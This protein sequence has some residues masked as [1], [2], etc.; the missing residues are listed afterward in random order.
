MRKLIIVISLLVVLF[1]CTAPKTVLE[2]DKHITADNNTKKISEEDII[3]DQEKPKKVEEENPVEEKISKEVSEESLS[4]EEPSQFQLRDIQYELDSTGESFK[5]TNLRLIIDN[6]T[7]KNLDTTAKIYVDNELYDEINP[8][9]IE[10]FSTLNQTFTISGVKLPFSE[11]KE[12]KVKIYEGNR[13][14]S[15]LKQLLKLSSGPSVNANITKIGFRVEDDK[16]WVENVTIR[17]E[18]HVGDHLLWTA[19]F[20]AFDESDPS[21]L[22]SI[23]YDEFE[24]PLILS[25]QTLEE[26]FPVE[27]RSIGNLGANKT[28]ILRLYDKNVLKKEV[29]L[30]QVVG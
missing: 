8:H 16:F 22:K 21:A 3:E 23:P 19:K 5:L 26:T 25:N 13:V 14:I 24:L 29:T 17:V 7:D 12:I 2:P 18:N 27:G 1:G 28:F 20:Y 4:K 10:E 15:E 11:N 30:Y 9:S 6:P